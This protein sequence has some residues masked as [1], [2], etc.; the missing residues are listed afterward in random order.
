MLKIYLNQ[1]GSVLTTLAAVGF[2]AAGLLFLLTPGAQQPGG[3]TFEAFMLSVAE[4]SNILKFSLWARILLA[5]VGLGA[6]PAII[7]LVYHRGEEWAAWARNLGYLAFGIMAVENL[8]KSVFIP[9][10]AG[11]YTAVEETVRQAIGGDNLH[12]TLDPFGWLQFG[13]LGLSIMI[14]SVLALRAADLPDSWGGW[15][16]VTAVLLW[17]VVGGNLLGVPLV[18]IGAA[19]FVGILFAPVWFGWAG[20]M[21]REQRPAS[22]AQNL[23]NHSDRVSK[24]G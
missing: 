8:R 4:N 19:S 24:P 6:L 15:G 5:V 13:A 2:F 10:E 18:T 14:I 22:H 12:L 21:L 7:R 3:A 20:Y 16:L 9:L 1:P 11:A 17:L 23:P